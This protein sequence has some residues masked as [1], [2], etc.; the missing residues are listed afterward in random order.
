MCVCVCVLGVCVGVGGCVCGVCGW[1][2]V[3]VCVFFTAGPRPKGVLIIIGR[4]SLIST[5]LMI[6]LMME[7]GNSYQSLCVY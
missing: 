3:C 1:G 6:Q 5:Q 7:Q 2:C 4:S